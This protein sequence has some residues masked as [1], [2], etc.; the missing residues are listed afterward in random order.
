MSDFHILTQDKLKKN[1]S[2]I[3]HIP[4]PGT[5][6]SA[7]ITWQQAVVRDLGGANNIS[8]ALIDIDAAEESDLKAGLIIEKVEPVKFSSINLTNP[9]RLAEIEARFT[10]LMTELIA[11]KQITLDFIGYSG[12]V[13]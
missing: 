1:A 10:E 6:N 2:V 8:S 7:G 4:V 3:F 9:Q 11:E 5:N 12:D 13:T